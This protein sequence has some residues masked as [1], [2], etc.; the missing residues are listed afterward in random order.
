MAS[1][2]AAA[3]AAFLAPGYAAFAARRRARWAQRAYRSE[4]SSTTAE[5]ESSS[6]LSN[7]DTTSMSVDSLS[8]S[9][10]AAELDYSSSLPGGKQVCRRFKKYGRWWARSGKS[11]IA[12]AT[13]LTFYMHVAFS[14]S[15][16][17]SMLWFRTSCGDEAPT[18]REGLQSL[19]AET[20]MA[21]DPTAVILE[22]EDG[23][24]VV[25]EENVDWSLAAGKANCGIERITV[26]G[27][28]VEMV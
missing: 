20:A 25:V 6:T 22:G 16:N 21:D 10:T 12:L 5:L 11:P 26:A 7:D 17:Q 4:V 8:V 19:D 27:C 15:Q 3:A 2:S 28:A 9:G 13:W 24:D 23:A 1:A 18:F 14:N